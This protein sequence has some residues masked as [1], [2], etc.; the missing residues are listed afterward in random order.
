MAR[1]AEFQ[2]F[3]GKLG[4]LY[5]IPGLVKQAIRPSETPTVLPLKAGCPGF[6]LHYQPLV[7]A[8]SKNVIGYESLLRLRDA[9]G[10]L[11]YPEFFMPCLESTGLIVQ[12]GAW[13]LAQAVADISRFKDRFI[14]VNIGARELA[15]LDLEDVLLGAAQLSGLAL[16]RV[17]VEVTEQAIVTTLPIIVEKLQSLRALGARIAID[18]FGSGC[19]SLARLL[20]LP[21]DL[22]KLDREFIA[23][24]ATGGVAQRLLQSIVRLCHDIDLPVVCEG[25]E[26]GYQA[27]LA[28]Q[29]GCQILQGYHYGKPAAIDHWR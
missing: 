9:D 26:S 25:V 5:E 28:R 18:D 4:D 13:G 7:D 15:E 10:S 27:D 21:C 3:A 14:A 23:Q 17:V 1:N 2:Q 29:T 22:V 19:S 12:V 24:A 11:L 6:E 16:N 8:V 20:Q